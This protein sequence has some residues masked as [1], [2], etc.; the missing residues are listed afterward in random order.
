MAGKTTNMSMKGISES[1]Y[2]A[3]EKVVVRAGFTTVSDYITEAVADKVLADIPKY[4]HTNKE[5]EELYNK[6][7]TRS[8]GT[9]DNI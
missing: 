8:D 3:L 9:T 4:F 5:R 1:Q 6:L 2:E 7:R